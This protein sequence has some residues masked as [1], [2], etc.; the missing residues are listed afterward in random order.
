MGNIGVALKRFLANKNTISIIGIIVGIIVIYMAYNWRV[1]SAIDP[2]T[3][4][5]AN[6]TLRGGTEIDN[7][8]R[9]I[10][11]VR[12][13]R[14]AVNASGNIIR[15]R[16]QVVGQ[17]VREG[18]TIPA[19]SFFYRGQLVPAPERPEL[20]LNLRPDHALFYLPLR[21]LQASYGNSI[22]P[23]DII[24]IFLSADRG[25]N[26]DQR[27]LFGKFISSIRVLAVLDRDQRDVFS[28]ASNAIPSFLV[29]ELDNE[30]FLLF[31]AASRI[32]GVNFHAIP[33]GR[34]YT[35]NNENEEPQIASQRI[36][37]FIEV[38]S[39]IIWDDDGDVITITPPSPEPEQNPEE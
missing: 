22:M 14:S 33:R 31:Q 21:D 38:N 12:I 24:D 4:P 36:R 5:M 27:I 37:W 7:P 35:E 23:G 15:E 18:T 26:V 13:N 6:E 8:D 28:S 29:F 17:F 34:D 1:Q 9:Q 11:M 2:I 3:I 30:M 32:R 39:D 10:T 20:I 25:G 19:G 16:N